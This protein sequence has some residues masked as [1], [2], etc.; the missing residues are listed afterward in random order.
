MKRKLTILSL[1][2][3]LVS[4]A[5]AYQLNKNWTGPK[6]MADGATELVAGSTGKRLILKNTIFTVANACYLYFY[7]GTAPTGRA[8]SNKF[9]LAANAGYSSLD[10]D[11]LEFITSSG[12]ALGVWTSAD[13][14]SDIIIEYATVD[15]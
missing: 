3:L 13:S 4:T 9:Y 12:E 14:G 8:I 5:F 10:G 15:A 1:I 11:E 2:I 6:T 7:S